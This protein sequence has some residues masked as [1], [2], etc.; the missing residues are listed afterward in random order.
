MGIVSK[1]FGDKKSGT[2][3]GYIDLEKYVQ[4]PEQL[5]SARM[6][7][8]MGEVQRYDDIKEFTDYVYGGN[9]LILDFSPIAEE[10]VILKRITND[11]KKLTEEINGDIAGIGKNLMIV[12]PSDVKIDRHK[13]RGKY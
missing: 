1:I 10:E 9:V 11:L 8:R 5:K 4:S 7:V 2:V 3:E 6:H 12:S 13:L